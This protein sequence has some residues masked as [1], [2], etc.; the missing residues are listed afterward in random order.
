[1]MAQ[2]LS[3]LDIAGHLGDRIH[4]HSHDDVRDALIAEHIRAMVAA[5]GQ[6]PLSSGRLTNT[7]RRNL[8][9]LLPN[10]EAQQGLVLTTLKSLEALGDI[11][12]V[13]SGHWVAP[14]ARA[15]RSEDGSAC[16][17]IGN[18]PTAASYLKAAGPAR[19]LC[20]DREKE[21][22]RSLTI[23]ADVW[24]GE[25][26]ELEK[27]TGRAIAAYS[28]RMAAINV[29]AEA[30]EVY[31]PDHFRT[32]RQFGLWLLMT[33]STPPPQ[34]P[35]LVRPQQR[36]IHNRPYLLGH[37]VRRMDETI[38]TRAAQVDIGDARRLRFGFDARLRA[39]RTLRGELRKDRFTAHFPRDMPAE[40][41]KVLALGRTIASTVAV[42]SVQF[43][44]LALPFVR[45]AL[46]RIHCKLE[47][48]GGKS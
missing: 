8:H 4:G 48:T 27:W 26:G 18:W 17:A 32:L 39:P 20:G 12:D 9:S 34:G 36:M 2:S 14:P 42:T 24:L 21:L 6:S 46:S 16:L 1:M 7:V 19:Y 15:V 43:P 40:E 31:A 11:V 10:D 5:A 13:G 3:S 44:A 29:S 23:E 47:L 41:T 22:A 35:R 45:R 37:F 28:N 38:L 30:F 33:S 25:V